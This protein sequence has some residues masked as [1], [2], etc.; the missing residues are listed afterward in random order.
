SSG[1]SKKFTVV[2]WNGSLLRSGFLQVGNTESRNRLVVSNGGGLFTGTGHAGNSSF[3]QTLVTGAGSLWSNQFEFYVGTGG[4]GNRLEVS[5]G[6]GLITSNAY[7]GGVSLAAAS[8]SNNSIVV[9]GAGSTWRN[10]A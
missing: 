10:R 5:D 7:I 4:A 2:R 6:G 9:T 1:G 8:A 3:N